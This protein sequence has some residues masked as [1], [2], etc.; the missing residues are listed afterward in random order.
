M[1][2]THQRYDNRLN[3]LTILNQAHLGGCGSARPASRRTHIARAHAWG[4][5]LLNGAI[6]AAAV[7]HGPQSRKAHEV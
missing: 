7:V 6:N 3:A 5:A 2:G 1:P 4:L